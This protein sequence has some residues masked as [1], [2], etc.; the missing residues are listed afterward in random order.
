MFFL[1][2]WRNPVICFPARPSHIRRHI[3]LNR[4]GTWCVLQGHLAS[5]N[6]CNVVGRR[7]RKMV[8]IRSWN[9]DICRSP[10]YIYIKIEHITIIYIYIYVYI[11]TLYYIMIKYMLFGSAQCFKEKFTPAVKRN[12]LHCLWHWCQQRM[13]WKWL[14][15]S[16]D[17]IILAIT[18]DN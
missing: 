4:S 17:S 12:V 1:G 5:W 11:Y 15:R 8:S 14:P 9:S 6:P 3:P 16:D 2:N 10:E 13:H 7:L 18:N